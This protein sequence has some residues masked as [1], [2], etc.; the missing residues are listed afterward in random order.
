[1]NAD[2]DSKRKDIELHKHLSTEYIEKR[3]IQEY[4]KCYQDNWNEELMHLLPNHKNINVL[5]LGCGTGILL[6][7]LDKSFNNYGLDISL[8]MLKYARSTDTG[9]NLIQGD[10]EQLPF[11]D[12]IWNVVISRS[13]IHHVP[14]PEKAFDE[15]YRSLAKDGVLIISEPCI[16]SIMIRLIR[17]VLYKDEKK[18]SDAHKA[19]RSQDLIK[20]MEKS[21]FTIT[22]TKNFGYIAYPLC[23][24]PDF[25]SIL[26]YI[27]FSV[28]I[29]KLLIFI[30][31]LLSFIPIIKGQS[32]HIII[33]AKK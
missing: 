4:S 31:K 32:W 19:F 29:T 5:D 17:Y 30:D 16:D 25:V 21:G 20:S 7:R 6:R 27:P 24:F 26:N 11:F 8:D 22:K 10:C 33:V 28:Y 3:Y 15:I 9:D 23:G 12:N 13:A 18:F 2:L 14:F 1:M